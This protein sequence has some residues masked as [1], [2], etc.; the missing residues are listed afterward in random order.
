MIVVRAME[1]TAVG[2]R[3]V[4][5]AVVVVAAVPVALVIAVGVVLVKVVGEIFLP[6]RF[7]SCSRYIFVI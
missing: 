2:V 3:I 6:I 5:K 4:A 7:I 1:R